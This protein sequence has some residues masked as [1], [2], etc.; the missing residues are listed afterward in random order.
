MIIMNKK[1]END[2]E[3]TLCNGIDLC[4]GLLPDRLYCQGDEDR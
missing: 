1:G 4:Y 2:E 3:V